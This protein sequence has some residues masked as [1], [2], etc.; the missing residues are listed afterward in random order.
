M[1]KLWRLGRDLWQGSRMDGEAQDELAYHLE[2]AA[3]DK[4]KAGLDTAEARRQARLELGNPEE[5]RERL[6]EGRTGFAL[7]ALL[8]DIA[9]AVRAL[10]RRPAFAA[11]CIITVALGVGA[12]TALFAVVDAVVLKP[13]PL[14]DPAALVRIYDTNLPNDVERSGVTSGNLGDWRRRVRRLQGIAGHYTMGRTLT[15]GQ[16]SEVVLTAQVTESFFPLLGVGAEMGRTFTEEETRVARFDSAAAPI[17]PDPVVVLAH[18]FWRRRFGSDPAVVG[19]TILLERRPTRVVGVMPEAFAIPGPEVQLFI[20]WG[21]TGEEPRDQHYVSALARLAPG[22]TV[23]QAEEELRGIAADLARVHP[24]TNAGWSVRLVSLQEDLVGDSGLTLT[25]LLAAVGLLL[26]VACANV[27][28][29]SL[30]RGLEREHEA[31]VRLALGATRPRLVRQFLME[32]LVVSVAGGLLGAVLA[33]G[34]LALAKRLATGVPRLHEATVDPRALFFAGGA[35]ILAVLIAGLP[36]AWRRSHSEPAPDL[37]GTPARVGGGGPRHVFRDALVVGEVAMAVVLLAG[38]S[39]LVRSYQHLHAVDP[40]FDPR[41]VLVAPIFLDMAAYGGAGRS[42]AYY[43]TLMERLHALPGVISAGG[44]TALPASPLGPDFER[45]VWP[46]E[47]PEKEQGR[48]PAWV[49]MVTPDYFRTL[50]IRVVEGRPFDSRETPQSPRAVILSR[51]LARRLWPEGGAVGRRLV[52]DYSTAGTYPYDVV[53]VV[54]DVRFGG[55]RAEPRD[56]IYLP[57]AQRPYLILNVAVRAAG[58]PRFLVPAIRDVLHELDP[59]KPAHGIQTLEDLQG[60][61]YSRDRQTMLIVCAFAAVAV[62]MAVLG[63]HGVLSH[64]VRER[65]REIGIRMAIGADRTHLLRWITGQGLRLVLTGLVLGGALAAA[66]ARLLSGL[67][68]GVRATDPAAVL[69]VA[70]LPLVAF[71]VSLHPAWKATRIDAAEVL[72]AG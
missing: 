69:A 34:A 22:T 71:L 68:F 47:K 45:P 15:V 11:I 43:A 39:L 38:A 57:H 42:R 62:L 17:S 25:V 33:G 52:V 27:A 18:G 7:D 55:P 37:A 56:E 67:L 48:R 32:P 28:L 14:P 51:G 24:Q 58:D 72:R 20:P 13:L 64:R 16:E 60:A 44:A 41:N 61:T 46:E 26:L 35:T 59:G 54:N 29:L 50:G 66:S 19:R 53:G 21:F 5:A 23:L 12:S 4:A 36:A 40:G 6:R 30:A 65:A 10:R 70:G 9:L 49:R 63:I 1:K 31:S 8:K 2:L 3:A